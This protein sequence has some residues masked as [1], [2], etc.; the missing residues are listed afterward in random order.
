[1]IGEAVVAD[2]AAAALLSIVLVPM[3]FRF[4]CFLF[5]DFGTC[6]WDVDAHE[7]VDG[8]MIVLLFL[9]GV[10]DKTNASPSRGCC[11]CNPT[12]STSVIN[13]NDGAGDDD[14]VII[15]LLL[16][17][18][19]IGYSSSCFLVVLWCSGKDRRGKVSHYCQLYWTQKL[20]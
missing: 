6:C 9:I 11:C 19:I 5:F 16:F 4:L 8:L 3:L 7:V 20:F 10:V 15:V 2:A 17:L 1:V 14:D 13:T 12:R 18:E